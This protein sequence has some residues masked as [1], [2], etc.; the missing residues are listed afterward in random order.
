[1]IEEE[2]LA[3]VLFVEVRILVAHFDRR[4]EL[5]LRYGTA[6]DTLFL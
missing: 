5:D 6:A 4:G 3:A 1:M 2:G